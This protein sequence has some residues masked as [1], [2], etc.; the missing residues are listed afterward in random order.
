[1]HS[2][3]MTLVQTCP[4]LRELDHCDWH[5][6]RKQFRRIVIQREG[7]DGEN[8]QYAVKRPLP[9]CDLPHFEYHDELNTFSRQYFD[10][11]DGIFD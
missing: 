2:V 6:H 1:M 11:M 4:H 9:R 10:V 7:K 3:I 8:V 5:E